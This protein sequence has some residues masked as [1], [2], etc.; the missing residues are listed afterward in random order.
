M[1]TLIEL[2][3]E[4]P[5]ENVLGTE[6]FRPQKTV[7]VCMRNI[8]SDTQLH[9]RIREHMRD[10]GIE[11]ELFFEG[12]DMFK[13]AKVLQT[14][15]GI[16][17]VYPDCAIDI[18][19]GTEAALFAAGL[20]SAEQEVPVFTYSR[21]QN[22]FYSIAHASFADEAVCDVR[23]SVS[24]ILSMAG[25]VMRE[26]RVNNTVLEQYAEKIP[27]F[28][29]LY[30]N[31]RTRW[32]RFIGYMQEAS[33]KPELR[34]EAKRTLTGDQGSRYTASVEI[35]QGLER[36]GWIRRLRF[37][38]DTVRFTFL[39][40]Q[41]RAW[42]RDIGSVLELYVWLVC[43][44]SAL[45]DDVQLSVVAE[46]GPDEKKDRDAVR[47]EI[48]V[49]MTGGVIP[50]FVSCKTGE[51]HTEALNELDILRDRFG[52]QMAK[53]AIVS[54]TRANTAVRNR[55]FELD[56]QVIDLDDLRYGKLDRQLRTLVYR[57]KTL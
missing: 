49:M 22:R 57:K 14:L 7:F 19:G 47:N 48:D 9:E 11:T 3:D 53:A 56:I 25:G 2:Y 46:W 13:P 31:N 20:L 24:E 23:Y 41:V 52:G 5:L 17:A 6:I 29:A 33:R 50:Y 30:L 45:F 37:D 18:T 12:T 55:A 26:G 51:I 38:E 8:A 54:A 36:I 39:D 32:V 40:K 42:L 27:D 21:K 4:R 10:R 44:R 43:K 1:Q 35:L 15:R 28:F 34:V 16:L